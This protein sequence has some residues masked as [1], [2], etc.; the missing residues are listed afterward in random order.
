MICLGMHSVTTMCEVAACI[1]RRDCVQSICQCIQESHSSPCLRSAQT[2]LH[3][4]ESFFDRREIWR[5]RR[6]RP[7]LTSTP[8]D[9]LRNLCALV[10]AQIVKHHHLT[11]T[12]CGSQKV[13]PIHL[14]CC[15]RRCSF[16]HH[17][18][19]HAIERACSNQRC[20]RWC[21]AR[22]RAMCSFAPRCPCIAWS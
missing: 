7:Q 19:T 3:L 17:R 2:V 8:R 20:I 16:Q 12:Q 14:K 18:G 10:G 11:S 1:C 21:V 9:H 13:L 5:I 15:R 4:R 6:Q 22:S